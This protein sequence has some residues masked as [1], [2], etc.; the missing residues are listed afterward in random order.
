[1]TRGTPKVGQGAAR[2]QPPSPKSKSKQ[3]RL[4]RNDD[5]KL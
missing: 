5:I 3:H 2:L 4:W 1:M